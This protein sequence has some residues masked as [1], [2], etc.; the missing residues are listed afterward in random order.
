VRSAPGVANTGGGAGGGWSGYGGNAPG[1]SG[2]IIFKYAG[3]TAASGGTI[4]ASGG[5]TYHT[6]N[7]SG[8]F[9]PA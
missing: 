6:F 8:T 2:V 3:G 1:G 4:S 9:T 7:S 5:Y